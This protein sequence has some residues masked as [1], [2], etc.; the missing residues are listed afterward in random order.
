MRAITASLAVLAIS[1]L[2]G[3]GSMNRADSQNML[4]QRAGYGKSDLLKNDVSLQEGGVEGFRN[5]PVPTR[6]RARVAAIYAHPH[7]MPNRDYFWG[8]WVS[9]VVE[10]DQWIMSKPSLVPKADVVRELPQFIRPGNAPSPV[11]LMPDRIISID[12]RH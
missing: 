4:D 7:E 6:S 2:T 11:E 8:G 1:I 10:Q 3:C 9:V 12:D 5:A